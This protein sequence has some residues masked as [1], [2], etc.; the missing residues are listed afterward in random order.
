MVRGYLV[1]NAIIV[2]I[3]S[4]LWIASVHL[5]Y[6]NRLAIIW[7]AI[8]LGERLKSKFLGRFPRKSVTPNRQVDLFGALWLL[9]I[10][11]STRLVN[12]KLQG[13]MQKFFD[14]VPGEMFHT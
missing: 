13:K 3:P 7:I 4:A 8:P 14:F 6:P 1:G 9:V 10:T 2:A 12:P 11:R 5:D